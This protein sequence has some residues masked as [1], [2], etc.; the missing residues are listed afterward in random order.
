MQ[1]VFLPDF[2]RGFERS[3]SR[4]VDDITDYLFWAAGWFASGSAAEIGVKAAI[5][6]ALLAVLS[7]TV[8]GSKA[9]GDKKSVSAAMLWLGIA[10]VF[11][12]GLAVAFFLM[13]GETPTT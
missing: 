10:L 2:V 4:L 8:G 1:T 6:I 7:F 9:M 11:G 5:L 13:W 12:V 3:Y